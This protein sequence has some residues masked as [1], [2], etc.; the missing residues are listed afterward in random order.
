MRITSISI[1]ETQNQNKAIIPL[2]KT[3]Y[4]HDNSGKADGYKLDLFVLLFG[5]FF[6]HLL[7]TTYCFSF[8]D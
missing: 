5:L 1:T 3:R 8:L 6:R 2:D 7:H 4:K